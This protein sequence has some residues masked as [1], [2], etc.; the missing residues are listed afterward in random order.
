MQ[1]ISEV[2][3]GTQG[4]F[5]LVDTEKPMGLVTKEGDT[6]IWVDGGALVEMDFPDTLKSE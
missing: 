4:S 5:Y 6:R 3:T 2:T 1:F